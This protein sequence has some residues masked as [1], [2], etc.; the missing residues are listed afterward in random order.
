MK[1]KLAR[2]G[3]SLTLVML[4]AVTSFPYAPPL[5]QAAPG[6]GE[7]LYVGRDVYTNATAEQLKQAIGSGHNVANK[8]EFHALLDGSPGLADFTRPNILDWVHYVSR[9][10]ANSGENLTGALGQVK[11]VKSGVDGDRL[12]INGADGSAKNGGNYADLGLFGPKYTDGVLLSG[13]T[14]VNSTENVNMRR[15]HPAFTGTN[16]T[17]TFTAP[18]AN[19]SSRTLEIY[20]AVNGGQNVTATATMN[21]ASVAT[22]PAF[23]RRVEDTTA[24]T[25]KLT[26]LKYVFTY[27]GDENEYPLV[28]KFTLAAG[29]NKDWSGLRPVAACI[30]DGTTNTLDVTGGTAAYEKQFSKPGDTSEFLSGRTIKL[31]AVDAP[32]GKV[33]DA[34]TGEDASLFDNPNSAMTTF[35]MP[36]HP[37]TLTAT[38]KDMATRSVTV[39]GGT[40]EEVGG[41]N[42]GESIRAYVGST[43]TLKAGTPP[44]GQV[45]KNWK[46][47]NNISGV[48]FADPNA[49]TTTFVMPDAEV[50][51]GVDY[52]VKSTTEP[53]IKNNEDSQ[54]GT[55][56]YNDFLFSKHSAGEPRNPV[57]GTT[58]F[59]DISNNTAVPGV[60]QIDDNLSAPNVLDWMRFTNNGSGAKEN[61]KA[62]AGLLTAKFAGT[63]SN[64]RSHGQ[65]EER[66][67]I[68][69]AYFDGTSPAEDSSSYSVVRTGTTTA[70]FTAPSM[71]NIE[72]TLDV[73]LTFQATNA[74]TL[75]ISA[76]MPKQ[77]GGNYVYTKT[78]NLVKMDT[79]SKTSGRY[80]ARFSFTYAGDAGENPMTVKFS[81]NNTSGNMGVHGVRLTEGAPEPQIY[82]TTPDLDNDKYAITV[83]K[84][85]FQRRNFPV[86]VVDS[87]G[88]LVSD[89]AVTYSY[90]GVSSNVKGQTN[91]SGITIGNDGMLYVRPDT[92]AS[93]TIAVT[94]SATVD[95]VPVSVTRNVRIIKNANIKDWPTRG[96]EDGPL[97][98]NANDWKLYF[99]DDFSGPEL[100]ATAWVPQYLQSWAINKDNSETQYEFVKDE[101]GNGYLALGA[102]EQRPDFSEGFNGT[103]DGGDQPIV[104][105]TSRD[106]HHQHLLEDGRGDALD[107]DLPDFDGLV[108]TKYGYFE[109][110]LRLPSTGDGAHFAWWMIGAQDDSHPTQALSG[111]EPT[112]TKHGAGTASDKYDFGPGNWGNYVFYTSDQGVEYDI[113]EITA[114]KN[115]PNGE[116]NRWLPVIHKNG[117]RLSPSNPA[118]GRWWAGSDV[119]TTP[120]SATSPYGRYDYTKHTE[121]GYTGGRDA[122]QEFH[123]YGF[124]WDETGTRM[125]I[126][127][128]LVY[129]SSRTA[130]YRMQTIL[131]IYLGRNGEGDGYGHDHG[132][133]PKEAMFDYFRIY[134]KKDP[135]PTS[136]VINGLQDAE[137]NPVKGRYNTSWDYFKQGSTVNL[138]ATV[139]D[140]FGVPYD[141]SGNPNLSIKWRFSNDIGGSKQLTGGTVDLVG[142]AKVTYPANYSATTMTGL[143]LNANTGLLTVAADAAKNQDIFLTAYLADSSNQSGYYGGKLTVASDNAANETNRNRGKIQ[144]TKHIKV[145]GEAPKPHRIFFDH[146]VMTIAPGE[147][148]SVKATVYDQYNNP[149][150][151]QTLRYVLTKDVTLRETVDLS[152][153]GIT[154]SGN[155]LTAASNAELG[156]QIMV[157]AQL[158]DNVFQNLALKVEFTQNQ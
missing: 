133:W 130:D 78:E 157:R 86:K 92:G 121:D 31:T 48:T 105:L 22:V 87:T 27:T 154:L 103:N 52:R 71:E 153:S 140:Q 142:A 38:Y 55:K 143:N 3:L 13:G 138:S 97:G 120:N 37:V 156:K 69:L 155:D 107:P 144:E 129:V 9:D 112:G 117:S 66:K 42:T 80:A 77:G 95:G 115:S 5:A 46:I 26:G 16:A 32:F 29:D 137:G 51:I 25:N 39:T 47:V 151:G 56:K 50:E 58:S 30:L 93:M 102:K 91:I 122:Y 57:A 21:G 70:E 84:S 18:S 141:I 7:A 123:V 139:L 40:A 72:R 136:I 124:E 134:K 131:S 96:A 74:R 61:R 2:K 111:P 147:T 101:T 90:E 146:P 89:P 54:T 148:I 10:G 65:N 113:L 119:S 135:V 43:I 76:T 125:Y 152:L 149:M 23:D 44:E 82:M 17:A 11:H 132:Y 114:D 59:S 104:A 98:K 79:I 15:A 85:L 53:G 108:T 45:F 36:N 64:T 62:G 150:P 12:D 128:H 49:S 118:N 110:R 19:G 88:N 67:N 126:D 145:S 73:Y 63:V 1:L 8:P 35:T 94:V 75:T 81:L 33:F 4:M 100:D 34:W 24:S 83:P 14:G 158:D 68:R 28:V 99:N 20:L 127:G 6:S 60:P 116:Y 106:R 109:T 41:S